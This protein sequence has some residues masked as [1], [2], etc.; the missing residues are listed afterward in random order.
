[1]RIVGFEDFFSQPPIWHAFCYLDLSGGICSLLS[2]AFIYGWEVLD[3]VQF[4]VYYVCW[5]HVD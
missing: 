4:D 5:P 1:M 2:Q 3:S